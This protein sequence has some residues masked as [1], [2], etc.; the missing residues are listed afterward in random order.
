MCYVYG[1][2]WAISAKNVLQNMNG[3]SPIQL[4]FSMNVTLPSVLTDKPPA[5]DSSC[6]SDLIQKIRAAIQSARQNFTKAESSEQLK[7]AFRHQVRTYSVLKKTMRQETKSTINGNLQKVGKHQISSRNGRKFCSHKTW[8][9]FLSMHYTFHLMK[10]NHTESS[11]QMGGNDPSTKSS[12]AVTK[13]KIN[14]KKLPVLKNMF[15]IDISDDESDSKHTQEA[16]N[17]SVVTDPKI[18]NNQ[19]PMEEQ[20]E[21]EHTSA[22]PLFEETVDSRHEDPAEKHIKEEF[23]K[24]E[25]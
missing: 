7:R 4:V 10:V 20:D 6:Q 5:L 11:H 19:D 18:Q 15:E 23:V 1:L 17:E 3:Y 24:K 14:K 22:I 2:P 21:I 16:Q 12:I 8:E 13:R 9:Q 25:L